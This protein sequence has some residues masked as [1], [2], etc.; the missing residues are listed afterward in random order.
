MNR[1]KEAVVMAG[2]AAI[3][4]AS[5]YRYEA[6]VTAGH[7]AIREASVYRCKQGALLLINHKP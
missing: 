6:A 5:V 2:H 3:R 1:C 7:A 4:E